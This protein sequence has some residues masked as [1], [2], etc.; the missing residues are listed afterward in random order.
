MQWTLTLQEPNSYNDARNDLVTY[1]PL[2]GSDVVYYIYGVDT[3][4][5]VNNSTQR[6]E[7]LYSPTGRLTGIASNI[8]K[9][10]AWGYDEAGV[11]YAVLY[12]TRAPV[13]TSESFSILSRTD[14]GPSNST[15]E[16]IYK[17]V[18]T[19]GNQTLIALKDAAVSLV[20]DGGRHGQLYPVCNE[21]CQ[22]NGKFS[23]VGKYVKGNC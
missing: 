15:L 3:P 16:L 10:L 9:V 14:K 13:Q 1:Q 6:D 17:A 4:T 11:P 5:V 12:E 8:Y 18:D 20:Q 23:E 2:N 7:Y 19:S 21:T 22:Q